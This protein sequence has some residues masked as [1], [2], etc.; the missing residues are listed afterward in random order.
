MAYPPTATATLDGVANTG[1]N[2]SFYRGEKH[3][4]V[5]TVNSLN[6]NG[7]NDYPNLIFTIK[8]DQFLPDSQA[9]VQK[10]KGVSADVTVVTVGNVSTPGV[11]NVV[12]H[13]ADTSGFPGYQ[14]MPWWDMQASDTNSDPIVLVAGQMTILPHAT[15]AQS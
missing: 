10:K 14:Y 12:L 13:Y 5:I 6:V 3:T 9:Q 2:F 8:A 11:I 15:Q 7:L 1:P 4:I